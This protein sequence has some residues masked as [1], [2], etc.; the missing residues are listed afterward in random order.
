MNLLFIY[1]Y[2]YYFLLHLRM[3]RYASTLTLAT[4][5][6]GTVHYTGTRAVISLA[7]YW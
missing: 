4:D 7:L 6:V 5:V 1:N 3:L 2:L